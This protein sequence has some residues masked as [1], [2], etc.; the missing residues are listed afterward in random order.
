MCFGV[1]IN[2]KDAYIFQNGV[3]RVSS[4]SLCSI[5]HWLPLGKRIR[6]ICFWSSMTTPVL[7]ICTEKCGKEYV[8]THQKYL[9]SLPL[10][11]VSLSSFTFYTLSIGVAAKLLFLNMLTYIY[12]HIYI[13]R[14]HTYKRM[15]TYRKNP[16]IWHR[17]VIIL[18]SN[19]N[20]VSD[21]TELNFKGLE[22]RFNHFSWVLM[23]AASNMSPLKDQTILCSSASVGKVSFSDIFDP[24]ECEETDMPHVK[25]TRKLFSLAVNSSG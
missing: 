22:H 15:Y 25:V 21:L 23:T 10:W 2:I 13:L 6:Q 5:P 20:F 1:Y 8:L 12:M 11:K 7:H 24:I 9:T 4:T 19:T 17:N 18:L 3:D 14:I 16:C